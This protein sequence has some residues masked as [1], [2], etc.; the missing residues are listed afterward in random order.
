[1]S[2]PS[3]LRVGLIAMALAVVPARVAPAFAD[4]PVASEL[5]RTAPDSHASAAGHEEG[6]AKNILEF[7]PSLMLSTVLVFGI[8][9]AVLW[10][11]A[12]GPLTEA[13]AERERKQEETLRHAEEA[14]AESARLLAEHKTQMDT[15][16]EQVRQMFEEARKQ[17]DVH[18]QTIVSR[19]QAEAEGARDRAQPRDRHRQGPG[20]LGDLVEDRRPR[21]VGRR[22]GALQGD[23]PRRPPPIGRL[24]HGRTARQ[25]SRG[26]PRMSTA[27]PDVA[28][29]VYD[30]RT[31]H[32]ARS[33]AE[34]L[35]NAA[36]KAD[37]VDAVVGELE[38]IEA[39]VL[40]PHPKFAEILASPSVPSHE[41]D[42]ILSEAF[43]GR[44]MPTVSRFL[45]VL[46]A[47][48]RLGLIAPVAREARALWDKRQNRKPVAIR[49]ARELD[50]GQK[51][52]LRGKVAA[53]I[54]ATPILSFRVDPSLIGGL[55]VQVGDDV[56][57]A[58]IKTR[59]ERLRA[60]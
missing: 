10:K 20:P 36:A 56:Y 9:L 1:M 43:D 54:G 37:E 18:A 6:Q 59:L 4:D 26:S 32:V 22:Q 17:A 13:L 49:S 39:D 52:A 15:A 21:R 55:V 60:I 3:I 44:A 27:A 19:A 40:R 42:R 24:G 34:A 38:E 12:W 53:M 7:K 30:E 46:N 25:R 5:S 41:K 28:G 51:E 14:R 57:D 31:A 23:E 48:G 11:F 2:R 47:H 29:T 33:Y 45:K 8:L 35:I 50:E 16:A 58:S